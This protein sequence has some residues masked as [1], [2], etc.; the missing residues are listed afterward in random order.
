MLNLPTSFG[1]VMHKMSQICKLSNTMK[2]R[3]LKNNIYIFNYFFLS[4]PNEQMMRG[5]YIYILF[6]ILI[7]NDNKLRSMSISNNEIHFIYMLWTTI[8]IQ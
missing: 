5:D 7:F 8:F 6:M 4:L 1:N 3:S 2:V